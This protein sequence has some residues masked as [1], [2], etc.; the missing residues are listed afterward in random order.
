MNKRFLNKLDTDFENGNTYRKI[1]LQIWCTKSIIYNLNNLIFH[2]IYFVS[3]YYFD[4]AASKNSAALQEE[5]ESLFVSFSDN[6]Q[7]EVEQTKNE[8]NSKAYAIEEVRYGRNYWIPLKWM[9]K[10]MSFFGRLW[11]KC[12]RRWYQARIVPSLWHPLLYLASHQLQRKQVKQ[13]SPS[14]RNKYLQLPHIVGLNQK[15]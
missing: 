2:A 7:L 1:F 15:Q 5:L 11:V 6:I 9:L 12:W 3:L 13:D 10:V 14:L 8:I 4:F